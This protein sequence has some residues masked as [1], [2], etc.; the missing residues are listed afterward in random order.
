M[1]IT[2]ILL[3]LTILSVLVYGVNVGL[4]TGLA[5]L[6]K[7]ILLIIMAVYGGSL[8][9][10]REIILPHS[11]VIMEVLSKNTNTFYLS[12]AIIL[13]A[14]GILTIREWRIHDKQTKTSILL[15]IITPYPCFILSILALTIMLS[16]Y[17]IELGNYVSLG[18]IFV[19]LLTYTISRYTK[20]INR[21]YQVIL[22]NFMI[23]LGTYYLISALVT[24]NISTIRS[25]KL[26]AITI[27][28]PTNLILLTIAIIVM[29]IVGII[30]NRKKYDILR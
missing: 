9:I 16:Q 11:T 5:K 10:T 20:L 23:S 18:L 21:P 15:S 4:A 7:T 22:G 3:A 26:A 6:S 12:L 13:L 28:S 17:S 1:D 19:I 24:P 25:E 2:N 27:Q 14:A 8:I 29:M 30:I